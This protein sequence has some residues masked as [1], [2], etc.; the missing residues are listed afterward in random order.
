MSTS[1]FIKM[2]FMEMPLYISCGKIH[3][4][5]ERLLRVAEESLYMGIQNARENKRISDISHSIQR[6]VESNGFSVVRAFVGHGIGRTYMKTRR[7][8]ILGYP[9]GARDSGRYDAGYR[10]DGQRRRT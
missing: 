1:A 9:G 8:R 3:K 10:A 2:D 7:S 5:V 4:D 6:H